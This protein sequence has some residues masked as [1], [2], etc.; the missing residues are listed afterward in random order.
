MN[1]GRRFDQEN[2]QKTF[3]N[4]DYWEGNGRNC[5]PL[6]PNEKTTCQKRALSPYELVDE[7][8]LASV[9]GVGPLLMKSLLEH[10][11]SA[12]NVLAAPFGELCSINRIGNVVA[13]RIV[14]AKDNFNVENLIEFCVA[15][16]IKIISID[17]SRYPKELLNIYAPPRI[18]YVRGDLTPEDLRYAV[19]IV[20]T[21]RASDYGLKHAARLARE[22]VDAGYTVV[23]GLALGIDGAAH[24]GALNAHGRTIAVLAGGVAKIYPYEHEDLAGRIMT[25]GALISEYPPLTSPLRGNFPARNRIISGMSL[26]VVVVESGVTGGSLITASY[27]AEQGKEVFAMPGPVLA[28]NSKGCHQLLREGA[29]LV[30]SIDDILASFDYYH[31]PI[32]CVEKRQSEAAVPGTLGISATSLASIARPPKAKREKEKTT[33]DSAKSQQKSNQLPLQIADDDNIEREVGVKPN[34]KVKREGD[35][36]PDANEKRENDANRSDSRERGTLAQLP[37]NLS[38]DEMTLINAVGEE[39]ILIDMII[40]KS[41]LPT[42]KV[43]A[44]VAVLEFKGALVRREGCWIERKRI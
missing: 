30:E 20:G 22:L 25:S 31:L 9:E 13:Q 23:S 8:T 17:D 3:G 35:F 1:D 5:G 34:S 37:K 36:A 6:A 27:A 24:R 19:A 11:G 15:N 2:A 26:G 43:V 10:F 16:D 32:P 44:L 40:R 14:G 28:S 41:G 33:K 39:S 38:A 18:L 42:A 12:K 7:L 21:R 29:R 4:E